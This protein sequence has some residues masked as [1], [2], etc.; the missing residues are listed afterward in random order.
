MNLV[1]NKNSTFLPIKVMIVDD[2]AVIRGALMSFLKEDSEIE[3]VYSAYNALIAIDF[4]QKS[5]VEVVLLDIEMPE[6]T[7]IEAIKKFLSIKPN[8]KILMVST[9]TSQN[10]PSTLKALSLGAADYIEKPSAQNINNRAEFKK[11]FIEK[12]KLLGYSSRHINASNIEN[13]SNKSDLHSNCDINKK[14]SSFLRSSDIVIRSDRKLNFKPDIIAI[15]SSTGGPKCITDLFNNFQLDYLKNIPIIIT[16]H[17]PAFFTKLFAEQIN[18]INVSKCKE[19]ENMEE[20]LPGH[21]YI[22]PGGKHLLVEKVEGKNILK[23]DDGPLVNFCKPAADPM[24]FSIAKAYKNKVLLIVLTGMGSDG[25]EGAKKI[26]ANGGVVI[27][28]DEETS[29]VWSMPGNVAVNNLCTAVLPLEKIAQ[30]VME[31]GQ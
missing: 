16:Q 8:L 11:F 7:G 27:A 9:L 21:I 31:R 1:N 29:V 6:M 4:L 19:A 30:Y 14:V 25:L 24:L 17:M 13:I 26:V 28:Q 5:E 15:A 18:Q 10:A 2:S 23:L 20:V 22:A 3:V 12:V